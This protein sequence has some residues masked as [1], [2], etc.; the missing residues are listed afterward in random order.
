MVANFLSSFT[1]Q[2]EEDFVDDYFLDEHL[3][4]ITTQIPWFIDMENY[5]VT[6]MLP[7]YFTTKEKVRLIRQSSTFS[8]IRGYLFKL[9]MDNVLRRCIK[10]DEMFDIL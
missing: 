4:A 9:G 5:L 1:H 8:W 3:F 10:E 6:G 2:K 7:K